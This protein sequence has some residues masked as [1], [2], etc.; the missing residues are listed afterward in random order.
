MEKLNKF[1]G[2]MFGLAVGD[3]VG[4]S[5]EFKNRGSFEPVQDMVGKINCFH[6]I[7]LMK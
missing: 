5:V 2:S 7:I 6:P 4:T 1:Q 3:A